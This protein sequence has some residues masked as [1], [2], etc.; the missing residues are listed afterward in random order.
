MLPCKPDMACWPKFLLRQYFLPG[1]VYFTWCVFINQRLDLQELYHFLY[2]VR[3]SSGRL[4]PNLLKH[5]FKVETFWNYSHRFSQGSKDKFN[6]MRSVKHGANHDSNVK[7]GA[8]LWSSPTESAVSDDD[9]MTM[10]NIVQATHVK[11]SNHS[12]WKNCGISNVKIIW[13]F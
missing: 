4:D 11:L 8:I 13:F 6:T 12:H 9:F 5:D 1:I 10:L 2:L 7:C 3:K